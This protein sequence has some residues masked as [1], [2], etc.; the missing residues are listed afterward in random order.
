MTDV[1]TMEAGREWRL[2]LYLQHLQLTYISEWASRVS[3]T[4]GLV[5]TKGRT[6]KK[7]TQAA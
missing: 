6:E 3:Q 2:N 1:Y 5:Q 4:S 7:S